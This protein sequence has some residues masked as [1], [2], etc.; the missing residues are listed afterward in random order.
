MMI[1]KGRKEGRKR[2]NGEKGRKE[3]TLWQAWQKYLFWSGV[4]IF[5][6]WCVFVDW[7]RRCGFGWRDCW[8]CL[9]RVVFLFEEEGEGSDMRRRRRRR[10]K[11]GATHK[12]VEIGKRWKK[13]PLETED[14]ARFEATVIMAARKCFEAEE[15]QE[16]RTQYGRCALCGRVCVLF[17]VFVLFSFFHYYH[18][19]SLLIL[20]YNLYILLYV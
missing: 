3:E 1:E 20:C 9:G 7:V 14:F 15:S 19:Y 10:S 6:F 17:F 16:E 13:N 18:F 11:W 8:E 4:G 12:E 2:K 5:C